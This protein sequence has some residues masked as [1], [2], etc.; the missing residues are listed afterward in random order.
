M[1]FG[2]FDHTIDAKGRISIPAQFRDVLLGEFM[3]DPLAFQVTV[4]D[5]IVTLAGRPETTETGHQIVGRVRHVP[6][7]VAV[8]DRLDYPPAERLRS[9]YD[10]LAN[11]PMD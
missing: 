5:G 3:V 6:G 9:P 10:V 1:F 7:V 2:R 11:F 8:R 4:M